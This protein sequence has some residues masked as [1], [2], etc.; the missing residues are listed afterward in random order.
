MAQFNS[1][2]GA[3]HP[4]NQAAKD[5]LKERGYETLGKTSVKAPVSK[6]KKASEAKPKKK[7]KKK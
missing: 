4:E 2:G 7:G 6:P 1:K 5:L 3:W